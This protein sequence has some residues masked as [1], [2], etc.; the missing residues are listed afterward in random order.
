[1]R[2]RPVATVRILKLPHIDTGA[3]RIEVDCRYSTT[4]ITHLPGD[5]IDMDTPT[6]TTFAVYEHEERCDGDCDTS[7]AHARGS[8]EAREHVERMKAAMQVQ[9][10]RGYAHERRN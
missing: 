8:Q 5:A 4:G 1:M 3:I 6:L 2:R 9:A 10:A 7:Q